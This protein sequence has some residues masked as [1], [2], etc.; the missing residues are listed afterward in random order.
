MSTTVSLSWL[1]PRLAGEERFK[2]MIEARARGDSPEVDRLI[3]TCPRITY[4]MNDS[5][6]VRRSLAAKAV[7][8]AFVLDATQFLAWIEALTILHEPVQDTCDLL[9]ECLDLLNEDRDEVHSDDLIA[10]ETAD[11]THMNLVG[12]PAEATLATLA[13]ARATPDGPGAEAPG[14]P[15]GEMRRLH[16]YAVAGLALRWEALS[17]VC[18]TDIGIDATTL[19]RGIWPG[20]LDRL[21]PHREAMEATPLRKRPGYAEGRAEVEAILRDVWRIV[22]FAADAADDTD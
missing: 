21:A 16:R 13:D 4:E 6:F 15:L 9:R 5:A 14:Y 22:A 3:D 18:R 1:Y 20:M 8:Q 17:A 10:C 19:L 11:A 2:L 7:V 12:E